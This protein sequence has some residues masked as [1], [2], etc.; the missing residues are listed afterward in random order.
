MKINEI[1]TL[2]VMELLSYHF[3][4]NMA[5][6]LIFLRTKSENNEN[7]PNFRQ[8]NLPSAAMTSAT[9]KLQQNLFY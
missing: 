6:S 2:P 9:N 4:V 1:V 3:L 7:W 8:P 5:D